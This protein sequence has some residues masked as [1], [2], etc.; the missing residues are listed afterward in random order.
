M[1]NINISAITIRQIG[2]FDQL[3]LEFP[4]K[5]DTMPDKAEIHILT[6][7][8]GTGK[9]TVL[10]LLAILLSKNISPDL[11][12]KWR[13]DAN[14]SGEIVTRNR[15][16]DFFGALT[17]W[18]DRDTKVFGGGNAV[19]SNFSDQ[20]LKKE[21]G[22]FSFA[23]FAYSGYRRVTNAK[24]SGIKELEEHPLEGATQFNAQT[25]PSK[26]IQWIANMIA[27]EAIDKSQGN[28]KGAQEQRQSIQQLE[29]AIGM[30][31]DRKIEFKLE[32][33]PY[34]VKIE[35]DHE[36]LDF[37]LLPD[38]LKSIVSWLSD[39]LMRLERVKWVDDI[40]VLKRNFILF[41]DEIEVHLHPA[42]QR[43][44][45]PAVQ[46]LFPNAQIFISTHSPFVVGSVDGA[47]IHK[48]EKKDG[49]SRLADGYPMLSE[50]AKSYRYWLQEVFDI[51][52][53]YGQAA[54]VELDK[55]YRLRTELLAG[56]NGITQASF[57]QTGKA[58]AKQSD[59]L[60]NI[61]EMEF[62]QINRRLSLNLSL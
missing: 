54:V 33:K 21:A 44:I 10:E 47:W 24:I 17:Y 13:A 39:L 37:N 1:E 34:A 51:T 11:L 9:S 42:W 12:A 8:N 16:K 53:E 58:L 46:N 18:F 26:I 48:L 49:D 36:R 35:L 45:L 25:D 29:E 62:R 41:L 28:S 2:P 50:D 56:S 60:R 22:V 30:I 3:T 15:R 40:P 23:A 7:E 55:F 19:V 32:T 20:L 5:P 38:G 52:S 6:G 43:K 61:I 57:V 31:I 27:G 59:E 4:A 14:G